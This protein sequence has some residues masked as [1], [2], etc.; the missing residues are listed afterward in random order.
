MAELVD[1]IAASARRDR[2]FDGVGRLLVGCS[3]GGDSVALVDIL[4]RLAPA[5]GLDLAVAHLHHGWRGAEADA[6]RELAR[7]LAQ[8]LGVPFFA[9][10]VDL[11]AAPGSR[12]EAARDARLQ[13]FAAVATDWAAD[14]VAL[15]HTADD[16]LETV[17]LHLA[18]GAARRGLGGMRRR[19]RVEGLLV[20]RPL[21]DCRRADL[22]A[23]AT[24]RSL[25][26]GED[27]SNQDIS[28]ARNRLRR[29]L[30]ADLQQINPAAV[31][32]V[33]RAAVLLQEDEE[34]LDELAAEATER[35]V[36]EEPYP[37]G[38]ALHAGELA[39]LPRPLQRRVVRRVIEQVRGHCRGISCEHVDWVLDPDG[40]IARD[41]P[42]VRVKRE[43]QDLRFLPLA[44]RRLAIPNIG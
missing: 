32:N 24:S 44:G 25:R 28:H 16:Q 3:G 33:A 26:W 1:S 29:R 7:C 6:H 5:F 9:Q 40:G 18:R 11:S 21:L 30:L 12:E 15:G 37:G 8:D 38:R 41:L 17:V 42:G 31:D 35:I 14:A 39:A 36:V 2:L 19:V 43:E 10:R 4:S 34:W 27:S 13:F 22:R 20:V 23:Y